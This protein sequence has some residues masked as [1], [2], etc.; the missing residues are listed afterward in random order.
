MLIA[1]GSLITV[2]G[3]V[4]VTLR[5]SNSDNKASTITGE[6]ANFDYWK[7]RTKSVEDR[8][9]AL[10]QGVED[11]EKLH[12]AE[13]AEKNKRITILEERVDYLEA[14]LSRQLQLNNKVDDAKAV[15]HENVESQLEELKQ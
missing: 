4:F 3:G 6:A 8:L 2:I 7:N 5:K 15:L 1:L 10:E 13:I 11:R 14:E 9:S 12:R